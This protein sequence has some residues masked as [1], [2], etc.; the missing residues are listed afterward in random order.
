MNILI[1]NVFYYPNMVGGAEHSVK[2]LSEN[3]AKLGHNV[4]IYSI[5]SNEKKMVVEFINNVKVYR[6]T[7]GKYDITVKLGRKD[8]KVKIA[9]KI[10]EFDNRTIVK[11]LDYVFESFNPH[12]VHTNNING[13]S[14]FIWRY[15]KNKKVPI[16]HTLRDYWLLSPKYDLS[17]ESKGIATKFLI[18]CYQNIMKKYIGYVDY[19]TGPSEFIVNKYQKYKFFRKSKSCTI[20]NCV[21]IDDKNMERVIYQK[22]ERTSKVINFLYVGLL[23]KNKGIDI[24]LQTFNKY[25]NKNVRLTICGSGPLTK[26]VHQYCGFDQRITYLGQLSSLELSKQYDIS[27]VLII[28]SLWD[29]PFGR[30]VIEANVHG[31][32][33][34]GSN[35]GGIPEIISSIGAG[36]IF[37]MNKSETLLKSIEYYSNRQNIKNE[38]PNILRNIG[39]YSSILQAKSFLNIYNILLLRSK[40]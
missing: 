34:I 13:I 31:S 1:V 30:V 2:V 32:V 18:Y 16:V 33:V 39:K 27:D 17:F 25:E 24:L 4:A 10:L 12:I 26:M 9:N 15:F 37:D 23:S 22:L 29:E 7:G 35:R 21:N 19:L 28:P 38:L 6:G 3:L 20:V 5:D 8:K 36:C 11:E 14:P 40:S